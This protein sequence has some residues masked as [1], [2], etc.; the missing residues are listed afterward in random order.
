MAAGG[1][2]IALTSL[3]TIEKSE[4]EIPHVLSMTAAV[5]VPDQMVFAGEQIIFDRYDKRERMDR[6]INSF[7]YFHSTTLL[8]LKRANRLF[9]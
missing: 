2:F 7:T 9:P 3:K 6:E 5:E 8:L 4:A 1:I